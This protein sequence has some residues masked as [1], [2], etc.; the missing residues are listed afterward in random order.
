[1]L[2]EQNEQIEI[3]LMNAEGCS[4]SFFFDISLIKSDKV[5]IP[6]IIGTTV[7]QNFK[8]F[9]QSDL[10]KLQTFEIYDRWGEKVYLEKDVFVNSM[11]GWNLQLNQKNVL[12]G[13][14]VYYAKVE[15]PDGSTEILAGDITVIF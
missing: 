3:L 14:Y 15:F 9:A 8:M 1:L 5:Y 4:E 6:N 2:A 7:Q 13:V 12:P 10:T 11:E